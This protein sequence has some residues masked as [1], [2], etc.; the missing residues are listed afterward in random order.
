MVPEEKIRHTFVQLRGY[1][2]KSLFASPL[3]SASVPVSFLPWAFMSTIPPVSTRGPLITCALS[4]FLSL[5]PWATEAGKELCR[6]LSLSLSEA[7]TFYNFFPPKVLSS[8]APLFLFL[9]TPKDAAV[10]DVG[11]SRNRTNP[12]GE[13][14]T[15]VGRPTAGGGLAPFSLFY[16]LPCAF[17]SFASQLFFC[18]PLPSPP[19]P[20][21]ACSKERDG[22]FLFSPFAWMVAEAKRKLGKGL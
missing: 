14:E 1:F 4:P 8:P 7:T 5:L 20:I 18:C 12:G 17:L 19:P 2:D 15:G 3:S 9:S 13:G 10:A 22:L 21:P 6:A 16:L 11:C